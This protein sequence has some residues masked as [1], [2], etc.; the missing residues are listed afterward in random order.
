[1][2]TEEEWQH[3]CL[4]HWKS[5]NPGVE[6]ALLEKVCRVFITPAPKAHY[7]DGGS[8]ALRQYITTIYF[9][10]VRIL[11]ITEVFLL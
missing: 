4:F 2:T 3:I 11:K 10:T 8:V 1:M 9:G 7:D 6:G 5:R